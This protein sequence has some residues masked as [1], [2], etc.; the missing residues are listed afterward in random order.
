LEKITMPLDP[1]VDAFLKQAAASGAPPLESLSVGEARQFIRQLFA[2]IQ[3]EPVKK[4]ENRTIDVNS[5]KLP[6]RIY[7]PEGNAPLPVLVYLHGGGWVIGDLESYDPI[8]R[9]LCNGAGSIVV[10]VDY[11]LAPE[12]KC[13]TPAEDCYA[14]T[15]W[16]AANA[17]L[18][19]GDAK[20]MAVGGDSA[21][22]NLSAVVAQMARDRG[23]PPLVFQLLIYPVTNHALDTASYRTN[24]EGYLLTKAAMEWFWGHYLNNTSEGAN[25]Y[26]SP[27]RAS[28]LA[29]LPPALVITAEYDPL[30]DEGIAYAEKLRTAGNQIKLS[31]YPG[32]IHGFFTL[33]Y[34][35]DRGK[36]AVA[37][38][39]GALR[40]A[41]AK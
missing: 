30:R 8:C 27:L 40:Q 26:I 37:E 39:C 5:A 34:V 4:V 9:S 6:I 3:G 28:N 15:K 33:G 24:A 13:P 7:I 19:G 10:S 35:F 12:H 36:D 16:V 2:P 17:S 31:N 41:F 11:R 25:P 18:F 29:N 21:G 32:M 38:A 20:R 22:G 23:G 14:A 1:Q